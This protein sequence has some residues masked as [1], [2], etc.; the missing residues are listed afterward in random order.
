MSGTEN[1]HFQKRSYSKSEMSLDILLKPFNLAVWLSYTIKAKG[2]QY[3]TMCKN[4]DTL[5]K[6]AMQSWEKLHS[7]KVFKC[8]DV[9]IYVDKIAY[10]NKITNANMLITIFYYQHIKYKYKHK[11]ITRI[12]LI[13]IYTH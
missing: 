10:I 13:K 7:S 9:P 5:R 1:R 4:F 8:I 11:F 2:I 3:L 12:Y 6:N